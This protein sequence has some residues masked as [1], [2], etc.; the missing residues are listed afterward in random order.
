MRR[1]HVVQTT[2]LGDQ[3]KKTKITKEKVQRKVDNV[4]LKSDENPSSSSRATISRLTNASFIKQQTPSP[5]LRSLRHDFIQAKIPRNQLHLL[6]EQGGWN[7]ETYLEFKRELHIIDS[8]NSLDLIRHITHHIALLLKENGSIDEQPL[9]KHFQHHQIL[10]L[11]DFEL[12]L[13]RYGMVA[14]EDLMDLLIVSK[15]AKA[16]EIK[17]YAKPMSCLNVNIGR[18]FLLNFRITSDLDQ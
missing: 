14:L 12:L 3:L 16:E 6:V 4:L 9:M 10:F 5:N 13:I 2:L 7:H 18:L 1:Y 8:D 15:L 11:A 17:S